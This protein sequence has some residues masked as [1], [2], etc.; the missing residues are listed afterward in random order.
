[1]WKLQ[2][3]L[4]RQGHRF[5]YA[6]NVY[7]VYVHQEATYKKTFNPF[8]LVLYAVVY[9]SIRAWRGV[10]RV[11]SGQAGDNGQLLVY[12]YYYIIFRD[13]FYL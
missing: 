12:S 6:D 10:M 9:E 1:M 13:V 11:N 8:L 2:V 5:F 7:N 3:F 4:F